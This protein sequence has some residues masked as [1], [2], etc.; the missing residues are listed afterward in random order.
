M[1]D[2]ITVEEKVRARAFELYQ[3]RGGKPGSDLHDW[4]QAEKE[5]NGKTDTK[6]K[7]ARTSKGMRSAPDY[8]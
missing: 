4:F 8:D 3:S 6:K 1:P 5:I 7:K 2:T